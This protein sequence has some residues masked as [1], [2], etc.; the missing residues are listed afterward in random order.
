M[1]FIFYYT[2]GCPVCVEVESILESWIPNQYVKIKHTKSHIPGKSV[3]HLADGPAVIDDEVI[4]AVPALYDKTANSL[5]VG[6]RAIY[7]NLGVD[8]EA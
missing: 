2:I 4:P 6:D 7:Q 3:L 8:G 1:R 5:F